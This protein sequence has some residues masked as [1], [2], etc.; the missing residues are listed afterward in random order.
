MDGP[1]HRGAGRDCKLGDVILLIFSSL[2]NRELLQ[3]RHE[4]RSD[5][6]ASCASFTTRD[7]VRLF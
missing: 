1:Y 2:Q 3:A 7:Q 4:P 5:V 6:K